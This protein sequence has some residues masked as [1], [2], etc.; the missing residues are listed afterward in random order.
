MLVRGRAPDN[1]EDHAKAGASNA[2][3][4][5]YRI[6]LMPKR[7]DGPSGQDEPG[8]IADRPYDD[9][10][11]VPEPLRQSAEYGLSDAPKQVLDRNGE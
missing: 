3:A 5:K 7:C 6:K 10:T 2:E 4:H 9:G 11:P 1:G 8:C